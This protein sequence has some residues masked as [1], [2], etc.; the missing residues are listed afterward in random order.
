MYISFIWYAAI[1]IKYDGYLHIPVQLMHSNTFIIIK[2][3]V[4]FWKRN[5]IHTFKNRKFIYHMINTFNL[6]NEYISKIFFL[7]KTIKV[8][9]YNIYNTI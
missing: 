8:F 3:K 6:N 9:L 1:C 5:V 7:K 4:Q 2:S